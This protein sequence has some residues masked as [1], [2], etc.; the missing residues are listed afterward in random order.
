MPSYLALMRKDPD[1]DHSVDFP[2]FPGC[3]TAGAT[4]DEAVAMA[5]EA[6]RGHAG[7]MVELGQPL[8]A[9]IPLER[10]RAEPKN[11]DAIPFLV[12]IQLPS[13]A[14]RVDVTLDEGL[15]STVDRAAARRG[16]TRSGFLTEAARRMLKAG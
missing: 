1:S 15:L 7:L 6:L 3:V 4:V 13:P 11:R 8:P 5:Q 9:P 12:S 16:Y 10:I 14:V 2:D